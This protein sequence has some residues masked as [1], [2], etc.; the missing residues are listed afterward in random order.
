MSFV[1]SNTTC[2]LV[3]STLK[4]FGPN[5]H[6]DSTMDW[7]YFGSQR[8]NITSSP[9]QPICSTRNLGKQYLRNAFGDF[10]SSN[11][12]SNVHFV[13]WTA[14][15]LSLDKHARKLQLVRFPAAFNYNAECILITE[16]QRKV[17][18]LGK[19]INQHLSSNVKEF[20]GAIRGSISEGM[21]KLR[22]WCWIIE[23]LFST[24]PKRLHRVGRK[25]RSI[26]SDFY[27]DPSVSGSITDL[28]LPH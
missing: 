2:F 9:S 4:R 26:G 16:L 27:S 22:V 28:L 17:E 3:R 7:L 23:D 21:I 14:Y 25:G 13:R 18:L 5:I 24:D 6:L 19:A 10:F 8:S 20:F 12:D 15:N 1:S 11:V